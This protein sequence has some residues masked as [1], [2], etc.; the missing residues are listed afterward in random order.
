MDIEN[1]T[2]VCNYYYIVICLFLFNNLFMLCQSSRV[3]VCSLH[4]DSGRVTVNPSYTLIKCK[5]EL[6]IGFQVITG[7]HTLIVITSPSEL[8]KT[9]SYRRLGLYTRQELMHF[10][11]G[12]QISAFE[13]YT[14][15]HFVIFTAAADFHVMLL[16]VLSGLFP[17]IYLQHCLIYKMATHITR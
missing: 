8:L 17:S 16:L 1:M 7:Y 5:H 9:F 3:G 2:T 10:F 4:I 6:Q 11:S 12:E 13:F 15:K 14:A